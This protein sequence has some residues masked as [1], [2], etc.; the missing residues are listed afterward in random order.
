MSSEV[1]TFDA[2]QTL[3]E[4]DLDF[5]AT[6]L[7]ERE[8]AMT[9]SALLAAAPG[10]WQRYDELVEAGRGHPWQAFMEALLAGAGVELAG[11]LAEWLWREQPTKNLFRRPIFDMIA[12]ARELAASGVRVAVL[13]NSEGRLAELLAEIGIADAFAAVIDSGKEGIEKPDPRIFARTLERIGG[14]TAHA[15][16]IGDSWS[17]DVEGAL[18]AGW[19]A[20]WFRGRSGRVLPPGVAHARDADET[21]AALARFRRERGE[22]ARDKR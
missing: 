15:V 12:L 8:V 21:R 11:E 7:G 19:R 16:H 10:A 6:R 9:S 17:A 4:L 18:A 14:D 13:S 2:G 22:R 5:L 1:V 20:V 3:I